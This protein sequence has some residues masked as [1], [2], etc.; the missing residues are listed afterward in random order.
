MPERRPTSLPDIQAGTILFSGQPNTGQQPVTFGSTHT[1]SQLSGQT[2]ADGQIWRGGGRLETGQ[3]IHNAD[4]AA[5]GIPIVLYDAAVATPVAVA[6]GPLSASGHK[7]VGI[8]RASNI[9]SGWIIGGD[10][11]RFDMIF[12]SGLHHSNISGAPGFTCSFTP[13]VSG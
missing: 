9:S 7:V 5:S 3:I 8:L 2:L 1:F 11:T 4:P 6:P 10:L 13:V 12:T